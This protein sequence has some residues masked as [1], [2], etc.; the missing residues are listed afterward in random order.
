[1]LFKRYQLVNKQ[2]VSDKILIASGFGS[3][4]GEGTISLPLSLFSAA[5]AAGWISPGL[6]DVTGEGRKGD[7][8]GW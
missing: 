8:G 5:D 6:P 1:M 2:T 3:H 7:G 4:K